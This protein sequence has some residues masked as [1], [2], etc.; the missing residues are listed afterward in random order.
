[1]SSPEIMSLETFSKVLDD[2]KSNQVNTIFISGGEPFLHP[3]LDKIIESATNLGIEPVL[4][5]CGSVDVNGKVSPISKQTFEKLR[6]NGLR[7]I[8]F[9]LYSTDKKK[10]EEI[11]NRRGSFDALMQSMLNAIGVIDVEISYTPF[12]TTWKDIVDI[13]DFASKVKI[14]KINILKLISQGR[15]KHNIDYLELDDNNKM[16][17][18]KELNLALNHSTTLVEIS[19]LYYDCDHFAGLLKSKYT[20]GENEYFITVDNKEL[21]GRKYRDTVI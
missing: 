15:A 16:S 17:F 6:L 9:S 11:T 5:S 13:I 19:K 21:P 14:K 1:M 4:Y 2:A 20:A 10:H 12:A 7:T 3:E 18:Y 8:S